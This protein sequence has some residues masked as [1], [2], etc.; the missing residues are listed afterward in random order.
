MAVSDR[1]QLVA[2]AAIGGNVIAILA[3]T[4]IRLK[5]LQSARSFAARRERLAKE[6]VAYNALEVSVAG[7]PVSVRSQ[8]AYSLRA[9]V[10]SHAV[11]SSAPLTDHVI[12]HPLQIDLSFEVTNWDKGAASRYALDM[13][14][15]LHS[16]RLTVALVTAHS[17]LPNMVM[18]NLQADNSVPNWGALAFRATFQQVHFVTLESVT[19]DRSK[20]VSTANTSGPPADQ[21]AT[22]TINAGIK[23]AADVSTFGSW[24]KSRVKDLPIPLMQA[25]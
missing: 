2:N 21:S 5:A 6:G 17:I 10:T 16:S 11:E 20:V 24:L 18:T 7:I 14:F 3:R 13:L 23:P 22:P 9:D 12:L 15:M 1:L 8:E 25:H 19:Y 4:A